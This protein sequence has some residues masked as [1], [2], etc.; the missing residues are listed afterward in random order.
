MIELPILSDKEW[1]ATND[2]IS[3][4]RC[5]LFKNC[6]IKYK[7]QYIDRTIPRED[8]H[9]S[10]VGTRF[11]QFAELFMQVADQYP[12]EKWKSFIHPDFT[13]E[14]KPFYEYF[15]DYEIERFDLYKQKKLYQ[16]KPIANEFRVI[17]HNRKIRGIIDRIDQTGETS[18]NVIEYKTSQKVSKPKLMFEFGF[19][20]LLLDEVP[21]L[22]NFTRTYTVI[23]PRVGAVVSFNPS[24]LAT[25]VK[26]IQKLQDA[27]KTGVFKPTCKREYVFDWCQI[28]SQ[29]EILSYNGITNYCSD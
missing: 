3:K 24:R 29:E 4:S 19:Y 7:K 6:E 5:V 9:A 20:D 27:I 11:H 13:V 26:Q 2:Y 12:V 17:N 22:K 1:D 25:I 14:E 21:E 18:I 23:N 28:C 15:I 8:S 16:W 10:T